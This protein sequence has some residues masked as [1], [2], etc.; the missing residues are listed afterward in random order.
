MAITTNNDNNKAL[1][2]MRSPLHQ[3]AAQGKL[4]RTGM[5]GQFFAGMQSESEKARLYEENNYYKGL[6]F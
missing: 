3:N 2:T 1:A 5:W 4:Q 6:K